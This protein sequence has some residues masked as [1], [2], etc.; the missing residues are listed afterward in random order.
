MGNPG[1]G[2]G[3]APGAAKAPFSTA[4]FGLSTS[5]PLPAADSRAAAG[6]WATPAALFPPRPAHSSPLPFPDG[7]KRPGTATSSPLAPGTSQLHVR[8][9]PE[10]SGFA[11]GFRGRGGFPHPSA[12]VRGSRAGLPLARPRRG[13]MPAL[14]AE[15]DPS[16]RGGKAAGGRPGSARSDPGS[17]LIPAGDGVANGTAESCRDGPEH[18]E[19][20]WEA[21]EG[22]EGAFPPAPEP[23]KVSKEAPGDLRAASIPTEE[24]GQDAGAPRA[25]P[26]GQPAPGG[27]GG[28][29]GSDERVSRRLLNPSEHQEDPASTVLQHRGLF[30]ALAVALPAFRKTEQRVPTL[31]IPTC[32]RSNGD[33]A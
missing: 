33:S 13:R 17:E 26:P 11:L 9:S 23:G 6:S 18:L 19:P 27:P 7:G 31:L 24:S 28:V 4:R 32:K 12:Q 5:F 22:A 29:V 1:G 15:Q 3:A 25:E 10:G 8:S 30:Q 21:P 20:S 16:L 14:P 2:P